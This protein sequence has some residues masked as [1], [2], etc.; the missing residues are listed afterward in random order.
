MTT[1]CM[2]LNI[3]KCVCMCLYRMCSQPVLFN[4]DGIW[5]VATM[6]TME[7]ALQKLHIPN[8]PTGGTFLTITTQ[9]YVRI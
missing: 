5:S 4:L 2:Q 7:T 9:R 3:H 6:I 1:F 8:V